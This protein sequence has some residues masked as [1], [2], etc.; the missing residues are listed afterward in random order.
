MSWLFDVTLVVVV[1]NLI[2]I[3]RNV[4]SGQHDP[5]WETGRTGIV[6]LF[7]WKFKDIA[8]ECERFLAP[9]G[10]AGVQ[11]SPVNEYLVSKDGAWW[12]RYQPI[13][14]K[15]ISRSGNIDDFL[16]MTTRCNRVGVRIYVDVVF[17]H[18]AAP[19]ENIYGTGG[20]KADPL[21]RLFPAVPYTR[22]DFNPSCAIQDYGN[23]VQVRNC[24]LASLPDLNQTLENVRERVV[25][26]LDH[27]IDLGV[28]GFRVDACK[29]MWPEDLKVIFGRM[30]NL[31]TLFGFAE[32]SRP[33]LFQEVIDL[34]QEK[35][36]K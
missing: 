16:D 7:E 4:V 14:Y 2:T 12:E 26:F 36:S 11:V 17:N 13:S 34:G 1:I 29:H 6:H 23:P 9:A 35:V 5:H 19:G 27:L 22:G 20:S 8:D 32:G 31:N 15:I 28:A 21:A 33:F 30:K 25:E 24:E 10:Y 18:M 3:S